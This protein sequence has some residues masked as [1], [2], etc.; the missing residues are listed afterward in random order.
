MA[1]PKKTP[2]PNPPSVALTPHAKQQGVLMSVNT[3]ASGPKAF[4]HVVTKIL[5]WNDTTDQ[6]KALDEEGIT[7][8]HQLLNLSW[9]QVSGMAKS[10]NKLRMGDQ[11]K[12]INLAMWNKHLLSTKAEDYS[13]SNAEWMQLKSEDFVRFQV[14]ILPRMGQGSSGTAKDSANVRV[15]GQQ[16]VT[17]EDIQRFDQTQSLDAKQWGSAWNCKGWMKQKRV[18]ITAASMQ[19]VGHVFDESYVIPT[20]DLAA[21]MFKKQ[22]NWIYGVFLGIF[23]NGQARLI[24]RKFEDE[25]DARSV[26]FGVCDFYEDPQHKHEQVMAIHNKLEAHVFP[27]GNTTFHNWLM[28]LQHL[29]FDWEHIT[30][31]HPKAVD[32]PSD[33]IQIL[34][35]FRLV[36]DQKWSNHLMMLKTAQRCANFP[37]YVGELTTEIKAQEA[38][39]PPGTGTR[40]V[41]NAKKAEQEKKKRERAARRKLEQES[42]PEKQ[43][44]G[45]AAY[46]RNGK[47]IKNLDGS[48]IPTKEWEKLTQA[49]KDLVTSQRAKIKAIKASV[50]SVGIQ[51]PQAPAPVPAVPSS[52]SSVM[53]TMTNPTIATL[54]TQ[55]STQ[56]QETRL[57]LQ[58]GVYTDESG[59]RFTIKAMKRKVYLRNMKLLAEKGWILIDGGANCGLAGEDMVLLER[60]EQPELADVVGAN[61]EILPNMKDLEMG[62]YGA[63]VSMPGGREFL[64]V[65]HD[66]IGF[67]KGKSIMSKN[68]CTAFGFDVQDTPRRH[69][70]RQAIFSPEEHVFKLHYLEGLH[71][72]PIRKPTEEEISGPDAL[73]RIHFSNPAGWNPSEEN[74]SPED[75]EWFDAQEEEQLDDSEFYETREGWIVSEDDL[76]QPPLWKSEDFT[77]MVNDVK[78]VTKPKKTRRKKRDLESCRRFFAW[79]P[80]DVIRRTFECTTQFARNVIRL[81]M[82]KHLRS[83]FPGLNV[84]R[85]W[86]VY[87]T[88]TFFAHEVA[89]GGEECAQL[90][91]G[92][93]SQFTQVY[94]M[95]SKSEMPGTLMDFIRQFGAMIG[96][97][98]DNAKEQTSAAVIDIQRNYN[99]KDMQCEPRYQNQN[100]AERKIQEVKA[101]A[102]TV[103]DRSGAPGKFWFLAMCY[104]VCVLNRI[105]CKS[106][107]WRT[108]VEAAFGDT[109]DI[110]DLLCFSFYEPVLYHDEGAKFPDSKEK[111]GR[112]VGFAPNVG[113]AL[114]FKILTAD[115]N[116]IIHRSVVRP[117]DLNNPNYRS[118]NPFGESADIK[119]EPP[120]GTGDK[121]MICSILPDMI[122]KEKLKLPTVDPETIIGKTFLLGGEDSQQAEVPKVAH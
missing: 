104:C 20:G 59:N 69:G 99:I 19:Q 33:A 5:G 42:L 14:Q 112:F 12:L 88:D 38:N 34:Y 103:L 67:G 8:V 92:K 110:S 121:G 90:Y 60:A 72:M 57:S 105:A 108:P 101:M 41:S 23:V 118:S 36:K 93:T 58:P 11:Q 120:D 106:L 116:M 47:W 45:N 48:Y 17:W 9:N 49:E 44:Y 15:K 98:S 66:M 21:V 54:Q 1:T 7:E 51:Q 16:V 100:P 115:T 31:P 63:V 102:N 81:P 117:L 53:S 22:N 25:Q 4:E 73:E 68:Q 2:K 62:T 86:E 113:D 95:K 30:G 96:L 83:R 89:I 70:G 119:H 61:D 65:F 80:T 82:R 91:C 75:D 55:L 77:R 35:L 50:N 29:F 10:T 74:D 109:P 6:F 84:R 46:G 71:Y 85:L 97:F 43:A 32:G 40:S 111:P 18:L 79:K 3:R 27:K 52:G 87:A 64:G 107:G 39:K 76:A 13:V 94:G 37:A 28:A 122:E 114:T 78:I 56:Q 24:M 26:F